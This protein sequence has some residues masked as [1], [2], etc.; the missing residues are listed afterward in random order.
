MDFEFLEF[1]T[2]EENEEI[3]PSEVEVL[4]TLVKSEGL[5]L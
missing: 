4:E 1:E 2:I 3:Q 5:I